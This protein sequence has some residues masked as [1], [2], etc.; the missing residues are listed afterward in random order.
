MGEYS[1]EPIVVIEFSFG[2]RNYHLVL[3]K[4]CIVCICPVKTVYD[5]KSYSEQTSHICT[6]AYTNAHIFVDNLE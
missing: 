4:F 6:H 5:K 1:G 2:D 3:L